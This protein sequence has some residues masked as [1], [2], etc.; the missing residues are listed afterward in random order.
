MQLLQPR[1]TERLSTAC[2]LQGLEHSLCSLFLSTRSLR[3][4]G[5]Y[6]QAACLKV[7]VLARFKQVIALASL[8]AQAQA[9]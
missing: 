5:A 8:C 7:E 9:K 6:S 2:S 4:G 3:T 1:K